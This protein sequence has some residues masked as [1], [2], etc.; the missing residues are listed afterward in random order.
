[1]RSNQ[2]A[3]V[4]VVAMVLC[5]LASALMIAGLQSQWL[6]HKSLQYFDSHAQAFEMAQSRLA[7]LRTLQPTSKNLQVNGEVHHVKVSLMINRGYWQ[8]ADHA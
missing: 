6:A 8:Y 5:S 4:L 7:L 3:F 1:M 2:R